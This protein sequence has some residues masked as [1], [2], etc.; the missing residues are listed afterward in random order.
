M[1]LGRY[2][3]ADSFKTARLILGQILRAAKRFEEL[4][5]PRWEQMT[6]EERWAAFSGVFEW[7]FVA[8]S[9]QLKARIRDPRWNDAP[10]LKVASRQ[11]LNRQARLAGREPLTRNPYDAVVGPG[12]TVAGLEHV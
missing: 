7:R 6:P 11:L 3:A 9:D 10:E 12:S 4:F 8:L 2:K 5:S 1:R